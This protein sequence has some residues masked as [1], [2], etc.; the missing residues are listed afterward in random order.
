MCSLLRTLE[1]VRG[2]G[3]RAASSCMSLSS[4]TYHHLRLLSVTDRGGSLAPAPCLDERAA[5][6][7]AAVAAAAT[8]LLLL[9][10]P[11]DILLFDLEIEFLFS[12]FRVCFLNATQQKNE[13][14]LRLLLLPPVGNG[15]MHSNRWHCLSGCFLS[16]F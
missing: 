11:A 8:M 1:A 5:A 15:E 10:L 7:A 13:N 14:I 6:V 12:S 9:L 4:V 3:G 2:R 16:Q